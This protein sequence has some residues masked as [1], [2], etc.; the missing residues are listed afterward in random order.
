MACH[1]LLKMESRVV[2]KMDE[3]LNWTAVVPINNKIISKLII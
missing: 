2:L 1:F 3:D